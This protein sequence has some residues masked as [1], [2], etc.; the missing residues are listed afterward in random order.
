MR[1]SERSSSAKA[2]RS[3]PLQIAHHDPVRVAL[4]HCDLADADDPGGGFSGFPDL[5]LHVPL[6]QLLDRVP[7][8]PV[9]PGHVLI[10][11]LRHLRP[12]WYPNRL[13]QNGLSSSH[14]SP[15]RFTPPH[16]R[17]ST[18]RTSNRR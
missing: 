16:F 14:L 18:R 1:F 12:M 9:V 13:E 7:I 3:P 6:V 11:W 17:Q 15:S 4:L 5:L 2:D 8:E 10:V